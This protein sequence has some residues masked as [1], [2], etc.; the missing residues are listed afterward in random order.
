MELLVVDPKKQAINF[1]LPDNSLK[2]AKDLRRDDIIDL[3]N[4]IYDDPDFYT[5]IEDEKIDVLDNDLLKAISKQIQSALM[6]FQSNVPFLKKDI[7]DSFPDLDSL[8]S[9]E[10]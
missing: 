3:M 2:S 8:T 7:E 5:F 1:N 4:K 10:K 6:D 9:E